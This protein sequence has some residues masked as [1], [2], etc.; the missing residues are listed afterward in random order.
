MKKEDIKEIRKVY[1]ETSLKDEEI[2]ELSNYYKQKA[3]QIID[4]R[5]KREKETG[6]HFEAKYKM[7][8]LPHKSFVSE[9]ECY[10]H[11]KLSGKRYCFKMDSYKNAILLNIEEVI[12]CIADCANEYCNWRFKVMPEDEFLKEYEEYKKVHL[13][14]LEKSHFVYGFNGAHIDVDNILKQPKRKRCCQWGCLIRSYYGDYGIF[15]EPICAIPYYSLCCDRAGHTSA[16]I[17]Y[18]KTNEGIVFETMNS[19]YEVKEI[20]DFEYINQLEEFDKY[21]KSKFYN[22]L[23]KFVED[24]ENKIMNNIMELWK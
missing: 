14:D 17:D 20:K 5:K 23:F 10:G 4:G 2:D 6:E 24:E 22:D 1:D 12:N 11:G 3:K 7:Y 15:G 16:I 21:K 19:I 13:K 9:Y 8:I 18:K